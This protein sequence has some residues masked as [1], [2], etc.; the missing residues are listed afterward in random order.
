MIFVYDI[1]NCRRCDIL[2]D[3]LSQLTS[4]NN[5]N[6]NEQHVSRPTAG[7]HR[8]RLVID[9][10]LTEIHVEQFDNFD[11]CD[12]RAR[13]RQVL[14]DAMF[15]CS[16]DRASVTFLMEAAEQKIMQSASNVTDCVG[17]VGGNTCVGCVCY[18]GQSS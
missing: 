18:A 3:V 7:E 14:A 15:R 11:G 2:A 4:S 10:A 16:A 6:N 13:P 12:Q 5:N 1:K 8:D 17:W 9:I